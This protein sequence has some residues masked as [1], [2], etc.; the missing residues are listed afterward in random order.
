MIKEKEKERR[1][2]IRSIKS[3]AKSSEQEIGSEYKQGQIVEG[4]EKEDGLKNRFRC[5]HLAT[6]RNSRGGSSVGS[7]Y[8]LRLARTYLD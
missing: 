1:D 8:E 2:E 4:S 5:S 7:W 6:L 3:K